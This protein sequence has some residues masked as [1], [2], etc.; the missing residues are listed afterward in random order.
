[1]N[2]TEIVVQHAEGPNVIEDGYKCD[3]HQIENPTTPASIANPDSFH[4]T[5]E[6]GHALEDIAGIINNSDTTFERKHVNVIWKHLTVRTQQRSLLI[7]G[8]R[9]RVRGIYEPDIWWTLPCPF[10]ETNAPIL[11]SENCTTDFIT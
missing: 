1:M 6:Y 11:P 4:L 7:L 9:R 10:P 5:P 2:A 3:N 8:E